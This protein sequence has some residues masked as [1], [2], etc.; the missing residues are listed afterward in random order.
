[1]SLLRIYKNISVQS[2]PFNIN[3]RRVTFKEDFQENEVIDHSKSYFIAEVSV[4]GYS[5]FTGIP[6]TGDPANEP[7]HGFY[8][9]NNYPDAGLN[10]AIIDDRITYDLTS[11]RYSPSC[12]VQNSRLDSFTKGNLESNRNINFLRQSMRDYTED[13]L[14]RQNMTWQGAEWTD[15]QAVNPYY[16][17]HFSDL[18]WTGDVYSTEVA[19][20]NVIIPVK[21]L[22]MLGNDE[23]PYQLGQLTYLLELENQDQVLAEFHKYPG[24]DDW[25]GHPELVCNN[26]PNTGIGLLRR[27]ITLTEPNLGKIK[28]GDFVVLRWASQIGAFPVETFIFYSDQFLVVGDQL[29]YNVDIFTENTSI[30]GMTVQVYNAATLELTTDI[31]A[32]NEITLPPTLT[33]DSIP[34]YVGERVVISYTADDGDGAGVIQEQ[35]RTVVS[36]NFNE[37]T[38]VTIM[39]VDGP[40]LLAQLVNSEASFLWTPLL[41]VQPTFTINQIQLVTWRLNYGDNEAFQQLKNQPIL[42]DKLVV[43]P[44][45]R[46]ENSQFQKV[47]DLPQG[48]RKHMFLNKLTTLISNDRNLKSW[49]QYLDQIPTV[50]RDTVNGQ[51]MSKDKLLKFLGSDLRSLG[52]IPK[53]DVVGYMGTLLLAELNQSGNPAPMLDIRQNSRP[54]NEI[55]NPNDPS[56][57][58]EASLLYLYCWTASQIVF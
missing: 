23:M 28:Q 41:A 1:M 43:E 39:T 30:A 42:Y 33:K 20:A 16:R 36:M 35:Y 53:S 34:F 51:P 18:K 21:D 55:V 57:L 26:I 6:F 47:Y 11:C 31:A 12:L 17:T 45:N 29:V 46:V 52:H 19:T 3:N 32:G 40:P 9:G 37:N 49:R 15:N 54:A 8:F 2:G 24:N 7:I 48:T 10:P 14:M 5:E 44:F 58:L 4:T 38:G 13:E 50:D 25:E 22:Y 56:N 27:T